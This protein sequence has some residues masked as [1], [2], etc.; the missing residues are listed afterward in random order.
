MISSL[1]TLQQ[2]FSLRIAA[3]PIFSACFGDF[4]ERRARAITASSSQ[5]GPVAAGQLPAATSSVGAPRYGNYQGIMHITLLPYLEQSNLFAIATN[6]GGPT[7]DTWDPPVPG[8]SPPQ[9]RCQTIKT[10]QCPSD[11]TISNGWAA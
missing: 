7:G 4:S 10:Y 9:V 8:T 6:N 5:P 11:F 3:C 1:L 2:L